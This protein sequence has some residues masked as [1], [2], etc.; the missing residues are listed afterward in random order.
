[1][2]EDICEITEGNMRDT[3]GERAEILGTRIA[4]VMIHSTI[5][6]SLVAKSRQILEDP[7][8]SIGLQAEFNIL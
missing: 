6:L 2:I 4:S 5:Y 7:H 1:M 8:S 3:V